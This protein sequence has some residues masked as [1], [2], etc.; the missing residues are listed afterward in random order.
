[1]N[2]N[3]KKIKIRDE[4]I[5]TLLDIENVSFPKYVTQILNIANQNAQGTRPKVVGQMSDL[6][7]QFPGKNIGEW[8][9]WYEKRYPTAIDDAVEKI[10]PMVK[11]LKSAVNKIDE[12]TVRSWVKDLVITKTFTGLCFQEAILKKVAEVEKTTYR[13]ATPSEESKGIDGYIGNTPVSIKPVTY[14]QMDRVRETISCRIIFYEKK[15]DGIVIY[16]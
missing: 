7:Q 8:E 9:R 11:N 13:L 10:L 6:I 5:N 3:K 15:K 1:M 12:D 2:K 4:E 14:K 16:L